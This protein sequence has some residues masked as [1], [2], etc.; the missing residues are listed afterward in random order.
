MNKLLEEGFIEPYHYPEWL[1]KVV[2]VSKSD[3]KWPMCVDFTNLNEACL[4]DCYPLPRIDQ[5]IDATSGHAFLSFMD[6]NSR[7]HQ[8]MMSE[9]DKHKTTFITSR[10]LFNYKVM[11]FSSR[12]LEPLFKD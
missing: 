11:P 6:V 9:K 8:V 12:T 3:G 5:M 2:M 10:G 1:A 4:K 7:Y